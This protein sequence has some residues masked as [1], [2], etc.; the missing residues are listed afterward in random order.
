MN[1]ACDVHAFREAGRPWA[2]PTFNL[3][4]A[5]VEGSIGFQTVGRIPLRKK[6]ERGYRPGWDPEHQWQGSIPFE[7]LPSLINP[8]RGFVSTANNRVAA[9]DFPYPLAGCWASGHRQGRIR[10]SIQGKP[11]WSPDDCREL[12]LDI[13]S[14]RAAAGLPP[15]LRDLQSDA[16]PR[17]SQAVSLLRDWDLR[18]SG[19][20]VPAALFNV[21]FQH[22]C[23]RVAHERLPADQASL[24][25]G[26]AGGIAAR[27]LHRDPHGW[28][29]T[30]PRGQ[31][32]RSAFV[33]MLD[34]LT[35][36]LGPDMKRW[37]WGNLHQLQ[38]KHFLSGRGDLGTLLDLSGLPVGGDGVTVCANTFDAQYQAWLGAGYRM[39]ADLADPQCG[40]HSVEVAGASGQA[41]SPHYADQIEP[42]NAGQLFYVALR[43]DVIGEVFTL[44]PKSAPPFHAGK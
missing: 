27:L 36:R 1:R 19:Q 38:Q 37:T 4:F 28:F 33:S 35:K 3:V 8:A 5:D 14:R 24:A 41:H 6:G 26:N 30:T 9:D 43:D 17:V 34:D 13:Y 39:V 12:Q 32:I 21:F 25:A 20:S 44:E 40:F 15:L 10:E 11:T 18:V 2:V 22:W 7:G 23:Q 42:W 16:D 31:A 29:S